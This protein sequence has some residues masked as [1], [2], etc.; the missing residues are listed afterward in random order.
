MTAS[1]TSVSQ[2]RTVDAEVG[3]KVQVSG[4]GANRACMPHSSRQ[5]IRA[6]SLASPF[7]VIAAQS[8]SHACHASLFVM[9]SP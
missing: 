6:E 3:H 4:P 7:T 1:S 2:S 8:S 5:A 9:P